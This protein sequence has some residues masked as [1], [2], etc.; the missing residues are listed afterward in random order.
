VTHRVY[1][2]H[3][4]VLLDLTFELWGQKHIIDAGLLAAGD[5]DWMSNV[6]DTRAGSAGP[7][8]ARQLLYQRAV[9]MPVDSM[10]IGNLHADVQPVEERFATAIGSAPLLLGDLR[11]LS[12]A[13]RAWFHEK[14]AWFK[15]L[16]ATT[17]VSESFF[18]L[19]S[20]QQ[21]TPAAWDGFA[22]LAR[23]GNGVIS[24]FR[25]KSKATGAVVRLPLIPA[26]TYRVRS[27]LTG[28]ELR[29]SDSDWK[30]GVRVEFPSEHTVE[31]LEINSVKS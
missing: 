9:S 19:G 17:R 7:T 10:L 31:I 8:Q 26:G 16:R 5:L 14:I 23:S 22:R 4:D 28:K 27:V 18:P 11:K 1:Q 2:K 20:W 30:R 29:T 6:D 13:D 15:K 21:T 12:A 3:P 25:N 24:L